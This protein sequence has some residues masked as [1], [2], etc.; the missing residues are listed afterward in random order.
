MTIQILMITCMLMLSINAQAKDLVNPLLNADPTGTG[1]VM[2]KSLPTPVQNLL[3]YAL[4][5]MGVSYQW[6]GVK[7]DGG[8]DCSGFVDYVFDQVG[9]VSLPHSANAISRIGIRVKVSDLLPGDLVFFKF[10]RHTISHVG[11]YLG[12]N[13][14]I[15]AANTHKGHIIISNLTN[16][17]WSKH[18]T[19]GRRLDIPTEQTENVTHYVSLTSSLHLETDV[20]HIANY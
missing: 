2:L 4:K 18:F 10:M 11:I 7:P 6:G 20:S 3:I 17:Y 13:Q 19:L 16:K 5:Q 9:G 12:N 15:H 1:G 14:F 8:F